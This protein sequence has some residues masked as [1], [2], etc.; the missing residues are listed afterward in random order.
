LLLDQYLWFCLT[1]G[2]KA[3]SFMCAMPTTEL[4]YLAC[5]LFL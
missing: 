3:L 1:V 5:V 4:F 2:K